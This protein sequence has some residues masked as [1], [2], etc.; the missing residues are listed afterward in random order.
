MKKLHSPLAIGGSFVL[1][2]TLLVGPSAH[3]ENTNSSSETISEEQEAPRS[4]VPTPEVPDEAPSREVV[5]TRGTGEV[6]TQPEVEPPAELGPVP[7]LAEGSAESAW[8]LDDSEESNDHQSRS[9]SSNSRLTEFD[10]DL[11]VNSVVGLNTLLSVEPGQRASIP[12]EQIIQV[13]TLDSEVV[14]VQLSE[15]GV[16]TAADDDLP[17][18]EALGSVLSEEGT[19][20]GQAS[21]AFVVDEDGQYVAG[22]VLELTETAPISI[23]SVGGDRYII[24]PTSPPAEGE[25]IAL[26]ESPGNDSLVA[27]AESYDPVDER[28]DCGGTACAAASEQTLVT[29]LVGHTNGTGDTTAMKSLMAT[30]IGVTNNAFAT[31]KMK[32]RLSLLDT[33][34]LDWNHSTVDME[35]DLRA[36][37]N[38]TAKT[39][40]K[41]SDRRDEIGADLVA[42]ITPSAADN[43]CGIGWLANKN[44]GPGS[45]FSVTARSCL[46]GMTLQHEIGHNLGSGH[47]YESSD[48]DSRAAVPSYAFG[49][50]IPGLARDIM[51]YP[52]S[53]NDCPRQNQYATPSKT[54]INAPTVPSGTTNRN[55]ARV[56][57]EQAV[58]A[59]KYR[60][61][62]VAFDV[63]KSHKFYKEITWLVN[64]GITT[65]Y[66][67][68]TFRPASPLVREAMAAFLYRFAGK[69]GYTP[70]ALSP[71]VDVPKT[72]KFY[73]EISWMRAKGITTGN[74]AG[75]FQPSTAVTRE[76][77]SAF[78]YRFANK[79]TFTPPA[80]SPFVDVPKTHKF[81]KEISW[82][83]A[84][85]ITTG[86]S[87]GQYQPLSSVTREAMAAFLFRYNNVIG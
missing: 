73:K 76:A 51:A 82:M 48:A 39:M 36:A 22:A 58:R 79:P 24:E 74:S 44:S 78:L 38:G 41:L 54:F 16:S 63:P 53:G 37:T 68:G 46:S 84:K 47:D 72:H 60:A 30:Y 65:G 21:F 50:R 61:A 55:A 12:T 25:M 85:G 52:C 40:R 67:D 56:I 9:K 43:A 19:P 77:M 33:I 1:A 17:T 11:A 57:D 69:P 6:E 18:V 62:Q 20:E 5:P 45:G 31:S 2:L 35:I 10:A 8:F 64:R 87:S 29:V 66:A 23:T 71:F 42:V 32:T 86:N 3:A 27:P 14:S 75:Q 26:S 81:Y 4:E 13:S 7:E 15:I 70:P 34:K 49:Y 80:L 83:R 28:T 59:S